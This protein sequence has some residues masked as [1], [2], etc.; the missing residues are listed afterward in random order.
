[1]AS[2][3]QRLVD[4]LGTRL[5]R[6]VA[7]DDPNLRLLAY[8]SHTGETDDARVESIMRRS[9]PAELVAHVRAGGAARATGLFTVPA[10]PELGL[11]V[12]RVGMPVRYE[13][14]LLGFLWLLASDGPVTGQDAAALRRAAEN[15]ARVLHRDFLLGE[16]SRGR[17]RELVRD[18]I[19]AD[20]RVRGD[21]AHRLIEEEL[22]TAGPVRTLVATVTH[23]A[24]QPLGERERLALHLGLKVARLI[25]LR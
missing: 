14:S 10:R 17:E 11:R 5:G 20:E 18:L 22:I 23:E 9:V 12:A 25:E 4:N 6:S 16:L 3:L 7:L 1:M 19:S 21:A 13:H 15:T 8:N 24:G 2:E